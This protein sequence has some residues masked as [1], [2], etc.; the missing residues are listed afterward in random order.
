MNNEFT[1]KKKNR[2]MATTM[3][4][5]VTPRQLTAIRAIANGQRVDAEDLCQRL[6]GCKPE[7]L[8]RKAASSL[9]DFLKSDASKVLQAE[10]DKQK[11]MNAIAAEVAA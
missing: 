8:S 11:R 10:I 6:R 1:E 5:L 3:G 7:E 4:N 9:M 2:F